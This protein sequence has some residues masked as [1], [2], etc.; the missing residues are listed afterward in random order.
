[1]ILPYLVLIYI[2]LA[3]SIILNKVS[4]ILASQLLNFLIICLSCHKQVIIIK[5]WMLSLHLYSSSWFTIVVILNLLILYLLIIFL[6]FNLIIY[7]FALTRK[8]NRLAAIFSTFQNFLS[9]RHG[10][11]FFI[12]YCSL[13]AGYANVSLGWSSWAL[14]CETALWLDKMVVNLLIWTR[15]STILVNLIN[16]SFIEMIDITRSIWFRVF[17]FYHSMNLQLLVHLVLVIDFSHWS[18]FLRKAIKLIV[19]VKW[20]PSILLIQICLMRMDLL[21]TICLLAVLL[22]NLGWILNQRF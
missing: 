6:T 20:I 8:Y 4:L 14:S 16:Q 15:M 9:V 3:K 2:L 22:H 19:I 12:C 13:L 21:I 10:H 1:M 18:F 17:R 11:I 5:F 7:S